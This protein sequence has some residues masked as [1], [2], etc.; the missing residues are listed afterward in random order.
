MDTGLLPTA[1]LP[2]DP[3]LAVKDIDSTKSYLVGKQYLAPEMD[4]TVSQ[5]IGVLGLVAADKATSRQVANVVKAI[6]LLLQGNDVLAQSILIANAVCDHVS[7]L[8]D[9]RDDPLPVPGALGEVERWITESIANR[10]YEK[11]DTIRKHITDAISSI[12][13]PLPTTAPAPYRDALM[14]NGFGDRAPFPP[15]LPRQLSHCPQP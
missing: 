8:E 6:C 4:I 13:A 3:T 12:P 5:L 11:V 15:M 7:S 14:N 9:S 2:E 10:L 1:E